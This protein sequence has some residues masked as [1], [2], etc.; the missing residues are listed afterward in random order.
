M[1]WVEVRETR[2]PRACWR[3]E[4]QIRRRTCATVEDCER[5]LKEEEQ[6]SYLPPTERRPGRPRGGVRGHEP[7]ITQYSRHKCRG[8]GCKRAWSDYQQTKREQKRALLVADPSSFKHGT[9]DTYCLGC[10][11]E[12]CK[13]AGVAYRQRTRNRRAQ[14]HAERYAARRR[15]RRDYKS[16]CPDCG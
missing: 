6:C 9:W 15:A 7:S 1:G 10:T 5:V 3:V 2:N 14:L 13:E 12:A 8:E 11:C 16:R 4:G